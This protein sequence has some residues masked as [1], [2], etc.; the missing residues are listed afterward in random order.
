[1]DIKSLI[2]KQ[3]RILKKVKKNRE[4]D[5][6]HFRASEA[7]HC[8]KQILL[9]KLNVPSTAEKLDK[10]K[11]ANL[12]MLFNDGKYHQAAITD[13]LKQVPGLHITNIEEGNLINVNVN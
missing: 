12:E 1:M 7:G 2:L 10:I 3:A 6:K 9:R 8:K 4:E 13:Y 11:E 5:Y